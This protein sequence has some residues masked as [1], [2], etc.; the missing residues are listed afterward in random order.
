MEWKNLPL[1]PEARECL[2][3]EMEAKFQALSPHCQWAF[4]WA[5]EHMDLMEA[6]AEKANGKP[7]PTDPSGRGG[8]AGD[9]VAS[10][11][12]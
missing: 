5:L 10:R 9:R 7:P 8:A 3:A 2:I 4:L 6:L 11:G 1:S 12:S